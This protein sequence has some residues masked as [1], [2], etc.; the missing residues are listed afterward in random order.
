MWFLLISVHLK[1][2]GFSLTVKISYLLS[3][4]DLTSRN[5]IIQTKGIHS[6]S[7]LIIYQANKTNLQI[8]QCLILLWLHNC[9]LASATRAYYPS[10]TTSKSLRFNYSRNYLIFSSSRISVHLHEHKQNVMS[11]CECRM[12]VAEAVV[13]VSHQSLGYRHR[14]NHGSL[15]MHSKLFVGDKIQAG[16]RGSR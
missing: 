7:G 13:S 1:P 16:R 9:R 12:T 15:L 11:T 3:T 14:S 10:L 5:Y 6:V 2:E 4:D 8:K